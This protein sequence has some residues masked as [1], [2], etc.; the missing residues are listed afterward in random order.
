MKQ[1]FIGAQHNTS[2][3][4]WNFLLHSKN[5]RQ[6]AALSVCPEAGFRNMISRQI[7]DYC[8]SK[9]NFEQG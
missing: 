6:N 4:K 1:A 2:P 9:F 3:D 5:V 8:N 7:H